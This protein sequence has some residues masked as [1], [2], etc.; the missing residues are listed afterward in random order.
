MGL[1]NFLPLPCVCMCVRVRVCVYASVCVCMCVR[2][3][4]CRK[5]PESKN[6]L[7]ILHLTCT[8]SCYKHL[9]IEPLN[10][11][12]GEEINEELVLILTLLD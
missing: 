9:I 11:Q 5:P 7:P 4:V 1:L 12:V 8:S 3:C 6:G 2:V 10:L